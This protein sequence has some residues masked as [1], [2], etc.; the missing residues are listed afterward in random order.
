MTRARWLPRLTLAVTAISLAVLSGCASVDFAQSVA[1]ANRDAAD[2]TQGK[3]TL[4][5][6]DAQREALERTAAELFTQPL[7]QGDA[8]HLAL[9]NSPALQ[10]MLA[11]NW[12]STAN[13]AQSGRIANPIFALSRVRLG[14]ELDIERALSFGLLDLLTLPQRYG[15]AQRR[16]AQAQL[17]LTTEVIDQVTQVRQS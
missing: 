15:I 2:F 14:G 8:V 17:R 6:T 13:A 10:A 12:A 9:I 16:I 3:L 1:S 4:A 11:E 5:Q 7:G